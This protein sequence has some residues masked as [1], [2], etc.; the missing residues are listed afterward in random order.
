MVDEDGFAVAMMALRRIK[1]FGNAK[2]FEL[3]PRVLELAEKGDISPESLVAIANEGTIVPRYNSAEMKSWLD[4][5]R[6]NREEWRKQGI[7][8]AIAQSSDYP[9]ALKGIR[10]TPF[11]LYYKGDIA[12]LSERNVAIIGTR[13]PSLAGERQAKAI[14][15]D[16]VG[17]GI[18]IV[19]GLALGCD[20]AGHEGALE[21]EGYTCAVLAHG[22]DIVTP[23][24]NAELAQRI[25]DSGGSLVSEHAPGV[26]PRRGQYVSRN[27]IQ[28]GLSTHVIIIETT[29]TG[30]S[31]HTARFAKEQ[32]K[33][34]GVL[35]FPDGQS[36]ADYR[37]AVEEIRSELSGAVLMDMEGVLQ[38]PFT[39]SEEE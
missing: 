18:G 11:F 33:G 12:P 5:E 39:E 27:R 1:G 21:G 19:S 22:L 6:S 29:V 15:R 34:I 30:G 2:M 38:F 9:D 37:L 31:M 24:A 36:E 13:K 8:V 35:E 16:L 32:K 17:K 20:T 23:P 7:Q 25:L 3:A 26:P 4:A 14:A 28:S 10:S